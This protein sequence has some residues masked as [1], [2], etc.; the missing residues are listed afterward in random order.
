MSI[1]LPN[2]KQDEKFDL[3]EQI[4]WGQLLIGIGVM[5]VLPVMILFG[6]SGDLRWGMAWVYVGL[7]SVFSVASRIIMFRKNPDLMVERATTFSDKDSVKSWDKVLMP[8]GMMVAIIM[9]VVA[10]LD[11]RFG[12]SPISP[13]LLDWISFV[14]IALGYYLGTWA[15]VVNR[16]FS[17][18]VRIQADRGHIPVT[19]GPYRFVR[20]PAYA[21]T[22]VTSLATP[23]LLGS[24]WAL[25]PAAIAVCLL[26]IRTLLEDKMLLEE[27]EGYGDYAACVRFRLFPGMW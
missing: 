27:L 11:R 14:L 23:F 19:S 9:L 2:K 6:F 10:G 3:I 25:I 26:V 21:G 8:L 18:V 15:T 17:S 12:W 5:L 13:V 22:V 4:G 24:L 7:T 1:N 16:F 20:H